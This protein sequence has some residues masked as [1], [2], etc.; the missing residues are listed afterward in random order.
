MCFVSPGRD[1]VLSP[2]LSAKE[3]G[4][5]RSPAASHTVWACPAKYAFPG[6]PVSSSS[7]TS[8]D[9][10]RVYEHAESSAS[11]SSLTLMFL[12]FMLI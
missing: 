3:T 9:I 8:P 4:R 2:R 6:A 1:S 5:A 11:S 7:P 12:D 10:D